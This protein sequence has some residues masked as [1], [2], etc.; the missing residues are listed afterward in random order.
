[1]CSAVSPEL[2]SLALWTVFIFT[3]YFNHVFPLASHGP[4]EQFFLDIL[5]FRIRLGRG[6]SHF[7]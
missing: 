1:M 6:G 5:S 4:F 2:V 3:I 7:R